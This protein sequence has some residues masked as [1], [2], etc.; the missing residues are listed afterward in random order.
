VF[1]ALVTLG[2]TQEAQQ[3]GWRLGPESGA[4]RLRVE[5]LSGGELSGPGERTA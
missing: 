5:A 1:R 2:G 4:L 3:Q